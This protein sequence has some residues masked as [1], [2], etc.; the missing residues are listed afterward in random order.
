MSWKVSPSKKILP[1]SNTVQTLN[2]SPGGKFHVPNVANEYERRL[3][4][5]PS[6]SA[7]NINSPKMWPNEEQYA[8]TSAKA[9][10]SFDY[11]LASTFGTN[12]FGRE[13]KSANKK[14]QLASAGSPPVP[15]L[16]TN[17]PCSKH[18]PVKSNSITTGNIVVHNGSISELQLTLS[19]CGK[20]TLVDSKV[21]EKQSDVVKRSVK[22]HAKNMQKHVE[23]LKQGFHERESWHH[24]EGLEPLGFD[25]N[26][27]AGNNS[28]SMSVHTKS[29][30]SQ[31]AN[32]SWLQLNPSSSQLS[33]TKK[34]RN[35]FQDQQA[36][37]LSSLNVQSF[38]NSLNPFRAAHGGH[39]NIAYS[40][41]MPKIVHPK[42]HM[43]YK[44]D[45]FVKTISSFNACIEPS[46]DI[47]KV[48]SKKE[49]SAQ[50]F[51]RSKIQSIPPQASK[52]AMANLAA[53]LDHTNVKAWNSLA[54]AFSN[55]RNEQFVAYTEAEMKDL[56]GELVVIRFLHKMYSECNG[57][58][59]DQQ[60]AKLVQPLLQEIYDTVTQQ[61]TLPGTSPIKVGALMKFQEL[62][63]EFGLLSVSSEVLLEAVIK[64]PTFFREFVRQ[65]RAYRAAAHPYIYNMS[66]SIEDSISHF[67]KS[68]LGKTNAS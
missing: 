33:S 23:W 26:E 16:L 35:G 24:R 28:S 17:R 47:H 39:G 44:D 64:F 22:H 59:D 20:L 2:S 1:I 54:S 41:S 36:S 9:L 27:E 56:K 4:G 15:P 48:P 14:K 57:P 37:Y 65:V 40:R 53:G 18:S 55:S 32:D 7:F 62:R 29:T 3:F 49:K 42:D 45:L 67:S 12:T 51:V 19:Q 61:G 46:F 11:S 34:E 38:S 52:P 13:S 63:T 60:I 58:E 5:A 25:G 66:M 50:L 6:A 21:L 31:S 43:G 10:Q 68:Q 8:C 30:V